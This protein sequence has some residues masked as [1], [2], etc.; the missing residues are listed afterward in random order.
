MDLQE[1]KLINQVIE[2]EKECMNHE[3]YFVHS[4]DSIKSSNDPVL[5]SL[6]FHNHSTIIN[7]S[8]WTLIQPIILYAIS[9]AMVF[10]A[11]QQTLLMTACVQII[12]N[13]SYSECA[14]NLKVQVCSLHV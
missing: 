4:R 11:Y 6:L 10:G 2:D 8:F 3:L 14:L 1:E 12:P 13:L 5:Q 9:L 7:K